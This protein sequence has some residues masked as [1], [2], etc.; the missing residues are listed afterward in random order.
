MFALIVGSFQR[1]DPRR[2]GGSAGWPARPTP[3]GA[4]TSP[5]TRRS[6]RRSSSATRA[7]PQAQMA[8]HFDKSVKALLAAGIN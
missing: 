7:L 6:P 4:T 2:P 1:R 3:T 8:E 5:A